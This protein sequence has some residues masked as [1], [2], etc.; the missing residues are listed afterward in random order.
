[1]IIS[2]RALDTNV[3]GKVNPEWILRRQCSYW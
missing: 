2:L 3:N 1:V